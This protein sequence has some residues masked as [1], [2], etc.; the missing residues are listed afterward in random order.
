M[1]QEGHTVRLRIVGD[2]PLRRDLQRQVRRLDL[3]DR[4]EFSGYLP[5]DQVPRELYRSHCLVMPSD[6]ETFGLALVEAMACGRPVIATRCGGPED[7]VTPETGLLI[8]AGDAEA[9]YQAMRR[10]MDR[11]TDYD[12]AILRNYARETFSPQVYAETWDKL[13]AEAVGFSFPGTEQPT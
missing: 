1:V 4:V 6:L 8:P 3:E 9:L 5:R 11:Y 7:I 10:M 13:F 2:G 12:P